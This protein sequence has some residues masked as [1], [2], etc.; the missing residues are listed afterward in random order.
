MQQ[1]DGETLLQG[2]L[3]VA[4]R[5]LAKDGYTIVPLKKNVNKKSKEVIYIRYGQLD[6]E[7]KMYGI[8]RKIMLEPEYFGSTDI[9][10]E[11]NS[12]SFVMEG[13]FK[14]D[15]FDNTFGRK[16]YMSGTY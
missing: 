4:R 14:F 6:C 9:I 7:N 10:K 3:I 11:F 5:E 8:G 16:I 15:D 1:F 12:S 2:G 13:E